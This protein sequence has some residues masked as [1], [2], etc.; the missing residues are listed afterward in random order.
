MFFER[1]EGWG[2]FTGSTNKRDERT[3]QMRQIS[4]QLDLCP[5]C[6][7]GARSV[8]AGEIMSVPGV[9]AAE[10]LADVHGLAPDPIRP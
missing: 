7:G 8:T 3:G 6:N 4:E 9:D 2:T 5:T 10:R 1:A